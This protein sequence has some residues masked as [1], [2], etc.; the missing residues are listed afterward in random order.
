MSSLV[1]LLLM[2]FELSGQEPVPGKLQKAWSTFTTDNQLKY[3]MASICVLDAETGS[4]IFEK[5][6]HTGLAPAST[7]KVITAIAAF[8]A[9][10]PSFRF[11]THLG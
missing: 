9:L 3:G 7:Q 4:V 10:G 6:S 11:Q 2:S 5:N 1:F 8:E